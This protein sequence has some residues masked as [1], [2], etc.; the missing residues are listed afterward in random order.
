M[1]WQPARLAQ[2]AYDAGLRGDDLATATALALRISGGDDAYVWR[3]DPGPLIDQR[4]L[5]GIDVVRF[6]QYAADDLTRPSVASR[7]M[8]ALY[9]S[10]SPRWSWSPVDPDAIPDST[11][12]VARSAAAHPS[13]T[14]APGQSFTEKALAGP[15]GQALRTA[16]ALPDSIHQHTVERLFR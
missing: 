14:Q 1:L 8:A 3:V 7:V 2:F 11:W 4:G 13:R 16:E 5:W 15:Y 9:G 6:P 10:S 12:A